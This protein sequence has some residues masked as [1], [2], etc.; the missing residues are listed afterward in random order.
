MSHEIGEAGNSVVAFAVVSLGIAD[1]T[2][3]VAA[4]EDVGAD[5]DAAGVGD[6]LEVGVR[7]RLVQVETGIIGK[8]IGIVER[9]LEIGG[10]SD[11]PVVVTASHIPK[12]SSIPCGDCAIQ[13]CAEVAHRDLCGSGPCK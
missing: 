7:P 2:G 3:K 4:T 12:V 5:V 13:I 11:G 8:K 6:G 1:R 9:T 10:A